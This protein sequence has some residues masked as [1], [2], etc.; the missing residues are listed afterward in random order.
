[1]RNDSVLRNHHNSVPD[2]IQRMIHILRLARRRDHHVIPDP[3]VLVDDR[4]VDPRVLPD[5]HPRPPALFALLDRRQR[6]VII[7]PHRHHPPQLA[8]RPHQAPDA[9]HALHDARVIDD[10]PVRHHRMVDVRPVD[11]RSGQK[12]RTRKHRRAHVEE[13]EPRQLRR[14]V[15]VR[16]EKRPDRPNVLPVA[17]VHV[18]INPVRLDRVRDDVLPEI[19]QAVVQQ[20]DQ[21]VPVEHINA[22]RRQEQF[23][24]VLDFELRVRLLRNLQRFQHRRVLRLLHKP[25]D[26]PVPVHLQDSQRP[27]L[28]LP[29]RNR[30]DRQFRVRVPVFLDN[31]PEIHPVQLVAAQDQ[32][33]LERMVQDVNEVLPHRV[34]R[35]LVPR[36]VGKRLLRRQ[37]LHKTAREMVELVRLGDVPVQ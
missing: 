3:R 19:R 8:A 26:P 20:P 16:L 6:L 10:A 23:P 31:P 34:R 30:R 12:P 18:R 2:E 28:L 21:H 11:L 29:H 36:R 7:A 22:H 15:Q 24:L 25:R 14:H 13:I 37:N 35:S 9:H 32:Q 5:P 33:M 1:M 4:V 27:R 17:L